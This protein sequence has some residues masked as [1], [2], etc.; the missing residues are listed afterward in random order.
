MGAPRC[1]IDDGRLRIEWTDRAVELDGNL[2]RQHCRCAGCRNLQLQGQSAI[3]E[4]ISLR[5]ITAMGYGLQ[6]IF[7]DGH[8]R[9]I[10]PWP[11]LEEIAAAPDTIQ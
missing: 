9:G 6:L 10:F 7:S 11:Y 1:S 2:L 5:A 3:A 4:G 8:D